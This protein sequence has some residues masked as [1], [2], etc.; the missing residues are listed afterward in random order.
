MEGD[1]CRLITQKQLFVLL[2]DLCF[3][4]LVLINALVLTDLA[5]SHVSGHQEVIY[6]ILRGAAEGPVNSTQV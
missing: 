5:T 6:V 1:S 4:A 2:Q 3:R